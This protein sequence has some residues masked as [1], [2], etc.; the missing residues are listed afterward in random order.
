MKG[1][2][3]IK[4]IQIVLN[5]AVKVLNYSTSRMIKLPSSLSFCYYWLF[6]ISLL[7]IAIFIT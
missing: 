1:Y 5:Y 3:Y 7:S 4:T 2:V 6:A